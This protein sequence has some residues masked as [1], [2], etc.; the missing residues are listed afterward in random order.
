SALLIT[1][2]HTDHVRGLPVFAGKGHI[3]VY[4]S[5]D[6]W[7][8]MER[9]LRLPQ[10]LDKREFSSCQDFFIGQMGV[11][12]FPLSHDAADPHGYAFYSAGQKAAAAT[13]LGYISRRVMRAL[14]GAHSLILESNH[15]VQLLMNGP[16]P[17]YLK[18][19]VI[20][21]KGHLSN[22][23]AAC[24]LVHLCSCGLKS[25]ML[26]HLSEQNNLPSIALRTAC[27]ILQREGIMPQK[28]IR[29]DTAR[30]ETG[31]AAKALFE[32]PLEA[33]SKVKGA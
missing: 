4:A 6:T 28:D 16:Y 10:T 31:L 7:Q 32:T 24:A 18:R 5:R 14:E 23:D 21:R 19:R 3:P 26:G 29:I 25:V 15:D 13:D 8:A 22:E 17:Y 33:L 30:K 27:E 2:E 20:S 1:H 11:E 9:K 12:P